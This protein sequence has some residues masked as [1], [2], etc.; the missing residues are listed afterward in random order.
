MKRIVLSLLAATNLLALTVISG[1]AFARTQDYACIRDC[2]GDRQCIRACGDLRQ[3]KV[4]F[5]QPPTFPEPQ[6]EPKP[7]AKWIEDAFN[8]QGGPGGGGG[9]GGNG[10]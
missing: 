8:G 4:K 2:D 10:R 1:S 3:S 9:G 6:P 7:V 5:Y